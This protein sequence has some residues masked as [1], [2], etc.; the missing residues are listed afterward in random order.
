MFLFQ[1]GWYNDQVSESFKLIYP[2]DTLALCVIS[3]PE[4]FEKGFIPFLKNAHYTGSKDPLDGFVCNYLNKLT[5]KFPDQ[6]LE[7]IFDYELLPSRRP[8]ILVQTAGH[9]SGAAFYYRRENVNQ[10]PWMKTTKI[11][12][13]SIHEKYSGWFGFRGVIIFQDIIVPSL[14][15]RPPAD[16]VGGDE[17]VIE[18]LE[19]FNYHWKDWSFRDITPAIMKYSEEQKLY[20]NTPPDERYE[21]I[22]KIINS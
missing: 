8:R 18:L 22:N 17:K 7:I 20:F 5:T 4:M 1:T 2:Y 3:T 16:V 15:P 9:V 21:I 19:K 11:Y 10:D 14:E 6:K 13:V 12:G